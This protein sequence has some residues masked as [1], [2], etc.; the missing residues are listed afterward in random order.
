[1]RKLLIIVVLLVFQGVFG[2]DTLTLQQCADLVGQNAK[3]TISEN[4]LIRKSET[5][6]HFHCWTLVPTL[7]GS[8]GLNTY[9]GRRV[10][11]FTNTFATSQVNSQ[12]FGMNTSM[13]VFNGLNFIHTKRM[14]DFSIQLASLDKEQKENVNLIR[15]ISIYENLCKLQLQIG[16][17]T[18]RIQLLET[19]QET[20]RTLL[21]S[22][23]LSSV[24]TLKSYNSLLNEQLLQTALQKD[25]RMNEIELNHLAG[26][27]LTQQH[28]YSISSIGNLTTK[29]VYDEKIELERLEIR[30]K[31]NQTELAISRSAILP[32][33]SLNGNLGTGYST[34]NKDYT[35]PNTPTKPFDDQIKQNLYEGIGLYLNIPI[36]NRGTWLKAQKIN[37]IQAEEITIQQELKALELEKKTLTIEQTIIS[38]KA[39]IM[40]LEQ[41]VSNLE[42]VYD[43]TLDLYKFQR[44]TYTELETTLMDWQAKFV[45]LETKKLELEALKLQG[46]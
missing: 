9:F 31:N 26:L 41:I 12:S 5:N 21:S 32:S 30:K 33:I 4:A 34:N 11:P 7:S 14:L 2:Q 10:D 1:M 35:L 38:Q 17:S 25:L 36:L 37:R 23:R 29:P 6:R 19:I 16:Y 42:K 39:E 27:S 13:P 28:L 8:A 45:E 22:G 43:Q 20:Q 46:Y 44:V 15:L 3:L 18:K 24:D 40:T